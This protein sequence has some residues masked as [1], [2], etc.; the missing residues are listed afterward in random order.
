MSNAL[1]AEANARLPRMLAQLQRIVEAESPSDDLD[2]IRNCSGVIAEI[3]KDETGIAPETDERGGRVHLLWRRGGRPRVALLA[4]MDTV[5]PVGTIG[6]FPF[7]VDGEIARGPGVFDMK[8]GIVQTIAALSMTDV[9]GVAL[10]VTSDEETGSATSRAMIEELAL[11]SGAVLVMEP[12]EQGALKI[13]RKGAALYDLEIVGRAAHAGLAPETGV[14]ATIE[15]AHV[16]LSAMRMGDDAVGTT[17]TPTTLSSGHAGNVIPEAARLHIDVRAWSMAELERVDRAI[18]ALGPTL[19]GAAIRFSGGINRGPL[20]RGRSDAL[21]GL[22]QQC[23]MELGLRAPHGVGVGGGSDGNIAAAVGAATLDGLGAVGGGAH[24]R[25]ENVSL[26]G[27][28][29]RAALVAAIL[30]KIVGAASVDEAS[31]RRVSAQ[32]Q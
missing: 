13:T 15:S 10:L 6:D 18:R 5:W 1:L 17:V 29:E 30:R 28:C 12:S 26:S 32:I 21:F 8:A 16:V 20:E 9:P 4:H 31:L 19:A 22:A 14:N 2:A 11:E 25:T 27:M 23:A 7:S 24:A 3:L